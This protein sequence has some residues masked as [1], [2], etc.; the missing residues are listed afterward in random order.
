MLQ[1]DWGSRQFFKKLTAVANNLSNIQL[2]ELKILSDISQAISLQKCIQIADILSLFLLR[3]CQLPKCNKKKSKKRV[4]I[5]RELSVQS[6]NIL[7][8][9]AKQTKLLVQ[10]HSRLKL[11]YRDK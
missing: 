9:H 2:P 5:S 4:E 6:S 1:I 7:L 8:T 10:T 11:V 3:K